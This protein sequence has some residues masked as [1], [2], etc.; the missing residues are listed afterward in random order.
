M[1]GGRGGASWSR[2]LCPRA[3]VDDVVVPTSVGGDVVEGGGRAS[4][5]SPDSPG[6]ST[7]K[8]FCAPDSPRPTSW[9]FVL[10]LRR[11]SCDVGFFFKNCPPRSE[12]RTRVKRVCVGGCRRSLRVVVGGVLCPPAFRTGGCRTEESSAGGGRRS[13]PASGDHRRLS[14]ARRSTS[15]SRFVCRG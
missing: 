10:P 4:T 14:G 9:L 7:N 1:W 15:R 12:V 6:Q 2:P 11:G 13:P 3:E 5:I 8:I